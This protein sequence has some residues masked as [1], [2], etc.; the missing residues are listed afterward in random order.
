MLNAAGFEPLLYED[1][2][3]EAFELLRK[4]SSAL[5][6]GNADVVLHEAFNDESL[7]NYIITYLKVRLRLYAIAPEISTDHF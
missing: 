6:E 2:A 7:Q 1:F 3:D 4:V 5:P